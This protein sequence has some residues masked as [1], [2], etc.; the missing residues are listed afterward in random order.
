M[1]G[2]FML[3]F[4]KSQFLTEVCEQSLLILQSEEPRTMHDLTVSSDRYVLERATD[5][6]EDPEAILFSTPPYFVIHRAE[7]IA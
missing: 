5:S 4:K 3:R 6:A 7:T 2:Q 1:T